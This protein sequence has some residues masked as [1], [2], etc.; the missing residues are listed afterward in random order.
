[1]SHF[2]KPWYRPGRKSWFVTLNGRQIS[3]GSDRDEAF[4]R[5]HLMMSEGRTKVVHGDDLTSV[6][7]AFLEWCECNRAPDTYRWYLDRIQ[8]F[9][10]EAIPEGMR[11][12]ELRPFHLQKWVDRI[13]G[14]APGTK[15]NYIRAVQRA[16]KW[17]E[18]QGMIDRSPIAHMEKPAGGKR[19]VVLSLEEYQL[20]L[21]HV[22]DQGFRD[23]LEV[24]WETGCRPQESLRV[25][26]RHFDAVHQRWIFP[27]TES[28][29][30]GKPRIVYLTSKATEITARLAFKNPTGR[31]FRNSSDVPWTTDAVNCRFTRL[32]GRIGRRYCLYHLR[33]TWMNR[34]LI[35]GVDALTVAILAGHSDPSMLAKTYQHLSQNPAYLARIVRGES[36]ETC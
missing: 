5:Y 14:I 32:T 30:K 6:L 7:D 34:M 15:R 19:E 21:S 3:L 12:L 17:A 33:H 13:P 23:L 29:V 9:A 18:Q 24:T 25:E 10:S 27:V 36:H 4:R 16:M 28:K 11:C 31:L 2:P 26:A 20:L 1:M 22:R 8:R 35:S